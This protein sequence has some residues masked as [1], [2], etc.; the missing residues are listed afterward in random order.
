MMGPTL[1]MLLLVVQ[2]FLHFFIEL[3]DTLL[4]AIF[5]AY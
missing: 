4:L 3:A 2:P 5:M 1:I